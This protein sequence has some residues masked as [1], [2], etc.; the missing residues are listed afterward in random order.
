MRRDLEALFWL[1][2]CRRCFFH[3]VY[4]FFSLFV[5]TTCVRVEGSREGSGDFGFIG[6]ERGGRWGS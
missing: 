4:K 1:V 3:K 5:W 6:E 2:D